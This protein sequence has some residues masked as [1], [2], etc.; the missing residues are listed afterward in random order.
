MDTNRHSSVIRGGMTGAEN[1][2][3]HVIKRGHSVK[4]NDQSVGF[5]M[6]DDVDE[7]RTE[8][9]GGPLVDAPLRRIVTTIGWICVTATCTS[10][11]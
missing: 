8:L 3:G 10:P 5:A 7:C 1:T 9:A 2:D 6:H 4:I 11:M